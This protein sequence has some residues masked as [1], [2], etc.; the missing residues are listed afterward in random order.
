MQQ[1]WHADARRRRRPTRAWRNY[2]PRSGRRQFAWQDAYPARG[3][4]IRR[5]VTSER[6][7]AVADLYYIYQHEKIGVFRVMQKL[8]S[9]STRAPCGCQR[10]GRV[11]A[12]PV[13]P[14]RCPALHP[15]TTACPPIAE[16]LRLRQR[17]GRAPGHAPNARLPQSF[18]PLHQPGYALLARQT[19]QRRGARARLRPELR[20]IAIVRRRRTGPAKQPQVHVVRSPQRAP[21]R[22]DAAPGGSVQDSRR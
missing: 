20:R 19:H 11:P 13:R 18:R 7:V 2:W 15:A 9:C 14:S 1:W 21:R 17:A 16:C 5:A 6:L 3:R 10:P 12:L 4:A 22:S 8:K